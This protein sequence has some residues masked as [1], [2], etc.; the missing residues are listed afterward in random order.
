MKKSRVFILFLMLTVVFGFFV[1]RLVRLQL[2]DG[3]SYRLQSLARVVTKQP[4]ESARGEILDRYCRPLVRN[5][6]ILCVYLNLTVC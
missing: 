2:M 6:T 3:E 4:E 1:L 5:E